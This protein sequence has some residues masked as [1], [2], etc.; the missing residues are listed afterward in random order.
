M[1]RKNLFYASHSEAYLGKIRFMTSRKRDYQRLA[2]T[3]R[4][5][6]QR[7]YIW[8]TPD[9][10]RLRC[11]MAALSPVLA[12]AR[13]AQGQ[14]AGLL[15]SLNLLGQTDLQLEGWVKE[16]QSSAQ[17]EGET[18]QLNSVRASVARRLGLT[19][20]AYRQDSATEGMLDILQSALS[21][22]QTDGRLHDQSL[23]AW[24][25]SLFPQGRSGPLPIKVGGLRTH[26]EPMQ[27]V[28]PNLGGNDVVHYQA[29]P[30]DDVRAQMFS[31]RGLHRAIPRRGRLMAW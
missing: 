2:F 11:D 6:R 7:T 21:L 17:I 20:S 27:I 16:A 3:R 15:E 8:Q 31:S 4:V 14:L 12:Q 19:N 10:P 30:S 23:H 18:L 13:R 25:A 9:W 1:K 29:P 22:A 5:A 26:F 28:T 24:H